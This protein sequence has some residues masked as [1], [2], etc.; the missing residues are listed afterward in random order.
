MMNWHGVKATSLCKAHM[1]DVTSALLF[2]LPVL[3]CSWFQ[4]RQRVSQLNAFLI[5]LMRR[6]WAARQAGNAAC[7]DILDRILAALEVTQGL[8]TLVDYFAS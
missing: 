1:P 7:G 3:C 8:V 4:Y 6:R 2:C 5:D